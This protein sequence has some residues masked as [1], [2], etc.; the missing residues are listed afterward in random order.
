MG[1]KSVIVFRVSAFT[2]CDA[3]SLLHGIREVCD[4]QFWLRHSKFSW[5]R[6]NSQVC[7]AVNLRM[8]SSCAESNPV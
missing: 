6:S 4:G 3:C 8:M 1:V 7:L 5:M 2:A